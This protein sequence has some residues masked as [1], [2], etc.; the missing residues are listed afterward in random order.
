MATTAQFSGVTTTGGATGA[1]QMAEIGI[2]HPGNSQDELYVVLEDSTGK[3][4]TV[5]HP[6]P[7]AVNS[8]TWLEWKIPL[9]NFTGVNVSK[10]K[11][12]Y[13]G[14][15]DRKSPSPDGSGLIYIDD[16]RVVKP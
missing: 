1:W 13:I 10:V 15:G 4:A 9:S 6:D 5:T 12:M 7:A 14:I 2:D 3:S 16:I 8:A 11:R